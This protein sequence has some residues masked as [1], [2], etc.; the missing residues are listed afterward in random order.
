MKDFITQFY[1]FLL[2]KEIILK[3]SVIPKAS[4]KKHS[5]DSEVHKNKN[6]IL[7]SNLTQHCRNPI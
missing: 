1:F 5:K 7:L 2:P 3:E 4:G 6:T